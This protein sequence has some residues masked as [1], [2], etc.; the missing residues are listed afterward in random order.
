MP[1]QPPRKR[2][3]PSEGVRE[4]ILTATLELIA[5]AG[6]ANLTTK[7]IAARA[8]VSE[9]S[10]HYHFGG[11][12]GLL[13]AVILDGLEPLKKLGGEVAGDDT[14]ERPVGDVLLAIARTLEGFF[15]RALPVLETIQAD[16]RLRASFSKRLAA[17]DLGPHRGVELVGNYLKSAQ[18][19]G[20]IDGKT[21]TAGAA[22]GLVGACFLRAWQRH[23]MGRRR[24]QKLPSL[25]QAV[26][27]L[28]AQLAPR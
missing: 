24:Q 2:G 25:E 21:D 13:Q 18:E 27:A 20:R 1:D 22:L 3:R 19:N 17:D 12:T 28:T 6:L 26:A 5:S 4:A 16:A 8:R 15:D 11:K 23:L 10:I 14:G 7:E 9:A